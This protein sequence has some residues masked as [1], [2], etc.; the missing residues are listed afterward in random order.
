VGDVWAVPLT[1]TIPTNAV[2]LPT[3]YLA[4]IIARS[5]PSYGIRYEDVYVCFPGQQC[6]NDARANQVVITVLPSPA[7][8]RKTVLTLGKEDL[9]EIK[10]AWFDVVSGTTAMASLDNI[11][12]VGRGRS[13]ELTTNFTGSGSAAG[14]VALR[15]YY[16]VTP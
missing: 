3:A 8:T 7:T 16:D 13:V 14:A 4:P 6:P 10:N 1:V 15:A 9:G 5:P 2:A 11:A 12:V